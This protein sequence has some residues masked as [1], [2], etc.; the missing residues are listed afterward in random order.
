MAR[1]AGIFNEAKGASVKHRLIL[2]MVVVM[3]VLTLPALASHQDVSDGN[4][5]DGRLDVR[6]VEMEEG[7]PRKWSITTYKGYKPEE[8]FDKGYMLV[9]FDI[10]GDERFD[11]YLLLRPVWDEIRGNLWKDYKKANDEIIGHSRVRKPNNRTIT[12]TVP[13]KKMKIPNNAIDYR[14]HVRALFAGPNCRRV[15]IDRA[16]DVG[17]VTELLVPAP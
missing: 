10:R 16:P 9:Y 11:Y 3:F 8:I 14:W 5:V 12:A 15:C 2:F 7:P 17:S 13:F 1:V 4:D 6:N